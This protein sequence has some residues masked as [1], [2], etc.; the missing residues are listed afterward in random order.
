MKRLVLPL[1]LA[2]SGCAGAR[3][4]IVMNDAAYPVSLSNGMRGPDG[5]L[6]DRS[7][8]E[9]VGKFHGDRT[10][11]GMLYSLVPLTPHLDL[12][13]DV[14]EQVGAAKGQAVVRL[15]TETRPCALDYFVIFS[16]LPIWPGCANVGVDGDIIRYKPIE[17]A[18][19]PAPVAAVSVAIEKLCKSHLDC[20]S[21]LVCPQGKCVTPTCTT[22]KQCGAGRWCSLEGTCG[23]GKF[24][25]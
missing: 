24:K 19:S 17:Q 25:R 1:L 7:E 18:P 2:L 10:A 21:G 9:V 3:S 5:H 16:L 13:K 12:S 6:L 14:N 22:D 23:A 4:S 15:R 11:W 20:E 8:M